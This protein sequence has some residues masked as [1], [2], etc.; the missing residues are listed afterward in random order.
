MAQVMSTNNLPTQISPQLISSYQESGFAVVR[1]VFTIP[2]IAAVSEEAN[3]VL[4]LNQLIDI[5]NLRCRW[6]NH[7]QT[8]ECRFDC[9]DPVIDLSPVIERMARDQRIL[10]IVSALYGEEACLFKDK[11]IYK[12]PGAKGYGLHQDYIGWASFPKSF[13]TVLVPI[14]PATDENGATEVFPG[15]HK[16]GFLSPMDGEY[17]ELPLSVVEGTPAVRLCLNPGDI[18][19]FDGMV[20]HRSDVNRSAAWRRQLY[21]SYNAK[22][23]GGE[24]RD[25]HYSKFHTWLKR[26]YSEY[27]KH[28]TYYA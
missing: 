23:D 22:S 11:L 17:H 7:Y 14:D 18:A 19:I 24:Q 6:Q 28:D 20:P 13:V 2:E 4:R 21:L 25:A 15:L 3:R 10:D 9:F 8:E 1:G 26:K 27:G 5:N 16:Q 12:P